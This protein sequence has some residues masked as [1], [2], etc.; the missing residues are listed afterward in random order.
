MLSIWSIQE[1][2]IIS[3]AGQFFPSTNETLATNSKINLSKVKRKFTLIE[4]YL[5][6]YCVKIKTWL[7]LASQTV[8]SKCSLP[9]W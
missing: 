1:G 8:S 9:L 6:I 7:L 4:I 2:K 3:A 5:N